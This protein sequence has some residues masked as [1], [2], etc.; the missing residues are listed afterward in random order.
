MSQNETGLSH[1]QPVSR[2]LSDLRQLAL[3]TDS[4][5]SIECL[6]LSSS[7]D[8]QREMDEA[9][10]SFQQ[11]SKT[12]PSTMLFVS[13]GTF[14]LA[15]GNETTSG[16]G[17]Q[18]GTVL[19][20]KME[21]KTKTSLVEA[22]V[23]TFDAPS[24]M[25][26]DSRRQVSE[27]DELTEQIKR[28]YEAREAIKADRAR[29]NTSSALPASL[30][31]PNRDTTNLRLNGLPGWWS[32]QVLLHDFSCYGHVL[33]TKVTSL[34]FDDR[35]TTSGFVLFAN[36]PSAELA[37]Y[38]KELSNY[39]GTL[40]TLEWTSP[41]PDIGGIRKAKG[42]RA[43]STT[44]D[45]D[46]FNSE[47]GLVSAYLKQETDTL[48]DDELASCTALLRDLTASRPSISQLMEWMILHE[49]CAAQVTQLWVNAACLPGASTPSLAN[50]VALLFLASDLLCNIASILKQTHNS[51]EAQSGTAPELVSASDFKRLWVYHASFYRILPFAMRAYGRRRK[52][53]TGRLSA[54]TFDGYIV[55]V[56]NAWR[57]HNI[58][59]L[60]YLDILSK[61]LAEPDAKHTVDFG[62]NDISSFGSQL[63]TP[64]PSERLPIQH[65]DAI[66]GTPVTDYRGLPIDFDAAIDEELSRILQRPVSYRV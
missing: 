5:F 30:Q 29:E 25:A 42:I 19:E 26:V 10:A 8:T 43:G 59:S 52:E 32:S 12:L 27:M 6:L 48:D 11:D 41:P 1:F 37:R 63:T 62:T 14:D 40:V 36:R 53:I 33:S 20:Y 56:L 55:S 22:K 4:T 2:L 7:Y 39:A 46:I 45:E 64:K 49:S 18:A 15:N 23:P 34:R 54:Q 58:F 60:K 17:R 38:D 44:P 57:K 21:A 28:K 13:A 47:T 24:A 50:K 16:E 31:A 3:P 51:S 35:R 61:I 65:I 66:D 9:I